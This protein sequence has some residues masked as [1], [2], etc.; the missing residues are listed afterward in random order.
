MR[1]REI[2]LRGFKS[3]ADPT[4]IAVGAGMTGVVGPNGCGKS[5]IVEA[6][7]WAMGENAPS[8]VRSAEMDEVIFAGAGDRAARNTAEVTLVVEPGETAMPDR[9][10]TSEEVEVTR[11]IARNSG[12]VYRID[13]RE[14]RARGRADPV[15]RC[16]SRRPLPRHRSAEPDRRNRERQAPGPPAHH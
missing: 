5:N 15:R 16:G 4:D 10:D 8:S 14:A 7:V 9:S 11:R 1:I 6:I 2:R 13:G 3:F 12:S